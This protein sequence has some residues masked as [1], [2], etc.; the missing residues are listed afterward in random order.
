MI[1]TNYTVLAAST[2]LN[3]AISIGIGIGI[4]LFIVAGI[5]WLLAL[6]FAGV[7]FKLVPLV[8]GI[9]AALLTV[10]VLEDAEGIGRGMSIFTLVLMLAIMWTIAFSAMMGCAAL[11]QLRMLKKRIV[12]LE[13]AN[14]D[15]QQSKL[16]SDDNKNEK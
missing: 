5:I 6:R 8:C 11:A 4:S 13:K 1:T 2:N 10:S 14:H 15:L 9:L 3:Q 16:P 7:I 12:V